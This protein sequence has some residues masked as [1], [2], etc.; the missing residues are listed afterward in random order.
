VGKK[1]EEKKFLNEVRRANEKGK[2]KWK[3]LQQEA[4]QVE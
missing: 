2:K 1:G 4:N 3:R